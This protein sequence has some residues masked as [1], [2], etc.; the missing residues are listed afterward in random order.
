M[1]IIY[2][3]KNEFNSIVPIVTDVRSSIGNRCIPSL[4]HGGRQQL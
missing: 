3:H 2:K 1:C 4:D